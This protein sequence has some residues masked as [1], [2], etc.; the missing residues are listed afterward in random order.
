MPL[1]D[2]GNTLRRILD[3]LTSTVAVLHDNT[4]HGE[5]N[6]LVRPLSPHACL[7][8]VIDGVTG[9]GGKEASQEVV[10]ALA[11]ASL[12]SPEAVVAT[13][14][15]VN[16]RLYQVSLG[17]FLLTTAAVA[18]CL[19]GVLH[20]V[21]AGDSSVLLIRSHVVH[22]LSHQ[23]R[24]LV[25]A[26]SAQAL[27]MRQTVRHLSQTAVDIAPDDRLLLLTDGITDNVTRDELA[28]IVQRAMAPEQAVEQIQTLL[29]ARRTKGVL[30]Q[31]LGGRF[32]NDDQ[33]A[34]VRF[35]S[36]AP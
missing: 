18:L 5:D 33:T 12:P 32:H 7:D 34:I 23:V 35:F 14:E 15:A 27:G 9:R 20:V 36:A 2:R 3:M 19:D 21:S 8:A 11:T 29:T 17:R 30:P 26:G 4:A 10:D 6:Y 24:G 25:Q 13:L 22:L 1:A 28:A 16:R 31:P